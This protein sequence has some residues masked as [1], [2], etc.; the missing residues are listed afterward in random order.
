VRVHSSTPQSDVDDMA[1]CPDGSGLL[2]NTSRELIS[3]LHPPTPY[4]KSLASW[5]LKKPH[6][7]ADQILTRLAG[8]LDYPPRD[9]M[10]CLLLFGATGM[11][12][13]R[14]VEKFLRDHR[15]R[16]DEITGLTRLPVACIQM[17]P[18]TKRTRFLRGTSG[19]AADG[20]ARRTERDHAPSPRASAGPTIGGAHASH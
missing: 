10:P 12:K 7:R 16:F 11:G 3:T 9:R 1:N 4:Y 8:L 2:D 13:T 5:K 15:S 20:A 6:T 19:R 14:L 17:P 18:F